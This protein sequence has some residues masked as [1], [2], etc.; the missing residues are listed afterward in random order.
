MVCPPDSFGDFLAVQY[1]FGGEGEGLRAVS[2]ISGSVCAPYILRFV[3]LVSFSDN[4]IV[5]LI[6]DI[7]C[8][9]HLWSLLQ[10]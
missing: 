5:V 2:N 1:F 7:V 10:S 6:L 4:L 3:L 8:H 9:C